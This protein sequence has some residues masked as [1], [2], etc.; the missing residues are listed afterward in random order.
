MRQFA[1][2][3][4]KSK[5][6]GIF[7]QILLPACPSQKDNINNLCLTQIQLIMSIIQ[8]PEQK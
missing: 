1:I 7:V 2:S 3:T 4:K 8:Y 6:T 5:K